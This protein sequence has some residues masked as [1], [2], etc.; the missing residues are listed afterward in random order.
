ME[1]KELLELYNFDAVAE[2]IY[3]ASKY[4]KG[5]FTLDKASEDIREEVHQWVKE[6]SCDELFLNTLKSFMQEDLGKF[7]MMK[8]LESEALENFYS[9]TMRDLGVEFE[10]QDK[11]L[12]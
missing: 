1:D 12:H 6:S 2:E 9:R 8:A 10:G 4:M 3:F 7:I 5:E 11:V